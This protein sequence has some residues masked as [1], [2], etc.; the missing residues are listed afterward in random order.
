[1]TERKNHTEGYFKK[2][3]SFL[4]ELKQVLSN[5]YFLNLKLN[6]RDNPVK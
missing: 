1:M 6:V 4:V 3:L 5:I 2:S